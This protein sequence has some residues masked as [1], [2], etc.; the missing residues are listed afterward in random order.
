MKP[1]GKRYSTHRGMDRRS[2]LRRRQCSHRADRFSECPSLVVVNAPNPDVWPT[3]SLH[4][5]AIRAASFQGIAS[6][7]TRFSCH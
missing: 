2:K 4:T 6:R 5:D 3:A 1:L 7:T